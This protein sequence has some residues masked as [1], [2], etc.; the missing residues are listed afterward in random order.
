MTAVAVGRSLALRGAV[1]ALAV[2]I[3]F[4][5]P[6][7]GL[8]RT[9]PALSVTGACLLDEGNGRVLYG[10]NA[11]A[12]MAIAST[13]KMMTALIVLQHEKH[14]GTIFTQNNYVP[15]A[16]DSQI[17]LVPRE[18][19]SVHDL[20][21]GMMLPSADDAAEDLAYN[22]GG[23]SVARF[24][25]MM[26]A[27][28][29]TLGLTHTHYSTPSGVDTPGNYSS[30]CDLVKLARYDLTYSPFF[31]R[32]VD[33]KSATLRTGDYVRHITNLDSLL[34][35][36]PWVNGVKTGHTDD[37]GWVLVSSGSQHGMTLIG[38]VL[39]TATEAASFRNGLALLQWGFAQ[40]HAV[41][42]I[43]A[44]TVVA[45]L[46]VKDRP[47][48]RAPVIVARSYS[49]VLLRST[50][51]RFKVQLPHQLVGPLARHAV[52]GSVIVFADGRELTR[53]PA[54]LARRLPAVSSLTL[55]ARFITRTS[56]L[57]LIV[58][59]IGVL[60]GL[61]VVRRERSRA[62]EIEFP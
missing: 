27:E 46:R 54:L 41:D 57:L 62:R 48:F 10:D 50:R 33:L 15:A 60:T 44:G 37:A 56:T 8:A 35:A 3:L 58:A 22:V 53:I 36:Y 12:H 24:I 31:R 19:M 55:A 20:L 13:T 43:R 14:L 32:M 59:V 38:S 30:P 1:V 29:V 21:L 18:R 25:A 40:F 51:L 4:A 2:L 5:C 49:K 6:A 52:V 16:D 34:A 61:A 26:N 17:G 11:D 28:A 39:G 42:V 47:G 9:G 23:G 45:R 7:R